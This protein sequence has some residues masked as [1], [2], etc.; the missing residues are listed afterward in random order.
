MARLKDLP[1]QMV[2]I[3]IS[4]PRVMEAFAE[5][6]SLAKRKGWSIFHGKNDLWIAAATRV[7]RA[8][9]LTMDKD[10]LPLVNEPGFTITVLDIKTAEPI[11]TG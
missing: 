8:H 3:P 2:F 7:S 4:D 9:L 10:F 6:S 1:K 5:I 11:A